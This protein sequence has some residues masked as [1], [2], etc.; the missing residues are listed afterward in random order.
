MIL[1]RVRPSIYLPAIMFIWGGISI[2]LA[3]CHSY[4]T[5]SIVRALLGV[6]EAGFSPGV[7]FLLSSWYRKNELARRFA[8]YY[9]ASALSGALG[10]I[11]AGAITGNLGTP[12]FQGWRW[13]VACLA[14]PP[15]LGAAL[16]RPG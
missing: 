7:L 6:V 14:G 3:G 9:T 5:L 11:L 13:C 16:A 8:V 2:A 10:G 4:I 1:T 15:R 12:S